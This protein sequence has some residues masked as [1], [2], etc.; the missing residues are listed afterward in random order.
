[1]DIYGDGAAEGE[2]GMCIQTLTLTATQAAGPKTLI[3]GPTQTRVPIYSQY[4]TAEV[5]GFSAPADDFTDEDIEGAAVALE[6]FY[7]GL[8]EGQRAVIVQLLHQASQAAG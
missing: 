6:T 4:Q 2:R 7:D 5:Q 1:L 3:F 8:P